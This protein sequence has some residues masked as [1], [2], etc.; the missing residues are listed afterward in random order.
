MIDESRL[1]MPQVGFL[2]AP[3]ET[4]LARLDADAAIIGIPYGVAY[5]HPGPTAGCADAPAAIRAASQRL[6]RF[7]G[8]HD[9]DLDGQM[10]PPDAPPRLVDGGDVSGSSDD[11]AGNA[12]RAEAAVSSMLARGV[13]PIVLGGDDSIPIPVIRA[14]A[15][16]GPITVLQVD[17]HLDYRDEVAGVR[18]GY[19]SPMRRASEM[20]HVAR[21]LHV[22][23][24]GVGSARSA[25]VADSVAAGNALVTARELRERGVPWLLAQVPADASVFVSFDCDGLDPS[26]CPAVSAPVPGGLSY[27][28][29]A[30]LLAGVGTRLAG[31]AITELVPRLD[32]QGLGALV[33]A[34]LIIRLLSH[35]EMR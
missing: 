30:D 34:R 29:A 21:I 33:A 18:D 7:R 13:V 22:G 19:S 9:F 15:D 1:T 26:V 12:A 5:P 6:A 31:A 10:L 11:G 24:R 3:V 23:L 20:V 17:A 8:H 32:P 28:E 35:M 27:T 14:F 2:A 25:D 16:Q 4:D